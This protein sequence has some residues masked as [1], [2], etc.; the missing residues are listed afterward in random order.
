[1]KPDGPASERDIVEQLESLAVLRAAG[2]L[3][4][5]EYE[6][7]KAR[8]LGSAEPTH[9]S[10]EIQ[11][12]VED[13]E[14][15]PAAFHQDR[16]SLLER[17][18]AQP[19][20]VKLLLLLVLYGAFIGVTGLVALVG[21]VLDGD[22]GDSSRPGNSGVVTSSAPASSG[23]QAEYGGEASVYSRIA[24]S[25]SCSQLQTDFDNAANNFDRDGGRWSIG[26]MEA[27]EDRKQ[28]IGCYD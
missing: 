4:D 12:V 16:P 3:T 11:P 23:Y 10:E 8:V 21:N 5:H 14:S 25:T 9:V 1:M 7:A 19:L 28:A 15:T 26:Y 24:A 6:V 22:N 17:F 27:A 20:F 18:K 2:N 13:S